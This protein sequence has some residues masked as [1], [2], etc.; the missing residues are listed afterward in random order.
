MD[1]GV[2]LI[3]AIIC[4]AIGYFAGL[5]LTNLNKDRSD[6][7]AKPEVIRKQPKQDRALK[8]TA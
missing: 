1:F 4:V 2:I 5:M 3:V 8:Q 7:D 6:P